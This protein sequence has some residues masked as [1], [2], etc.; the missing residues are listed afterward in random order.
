MSENKEKGM[1]KTLGLVW[2]FLREYKMQMIGATVALTTAAGTVLFMGHGLRNL[3][4][5]GL[6]Q[7]DANYL[8]QALLV[9]LV[10]I[11]ILSAASYSR[12]FL[13]SW[14]GERLIADL[15]IAVYKQLVI[16]DPT[17]YE[18]NKK[19]EIISRLTADTSIL[20]MIV[21]TSLPIGLRNLIMTSGGLFMLFITSPRLTAILLLVVPLVI[22]PIIVLGRRVRKKSR[23][24]QDKV[25]DL[26]GY[27]DETLHAVQTVQACGQELT[28]VKNFSIYADNSFM[29]ATTYIKDR[30]ILTAIVIF[31][32]FGAVGIV[33]WLG[34]HDVLS[35]RI[36][37][38]ELSAFVF[39]AIIVSGSIGSLS[40]VFGA[41]Q[42]GVGAADRLVEILNTSPSVIT[43]QVP[44]RL[45]K[46]VKGDIS[47][48]FLSFSY[49]ARQEVDAL[50][51]LSFDIKSGEKVAIVGP[52]GAGK[53][54]IFQ[55]L[56]RFYDVQFGKILIDK[57]D[58][59]QIP[60][61]DLRS[62][63]A[64]VPQ[65]PVV[66]SSSA[67][68]N[69]RYAS[70]DATDNAVKKAAK[71]AYAHTFIENLPMGYE[72]LLGER[73][74]T[75]SGGQKQ[76]IAIARAFLRNPDILLLDEAT[77][78]LDSESESNVHKALEKL[79]KGRTTL[80]IA[81]RLA[82]VQ[83]ADRILVLDQGH[84][85]DSGTHK[86]LYSKEGLYKHLADLQLKSD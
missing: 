58:I 24:A 67:L 30:A 7:R 21:S 74:C 82:T 61:E 44:E 41:L 84:L 63:I 3:I 45:A 79:M 5:F 42:R 32:I 39:Y 15:R 73:G 9:L 1:A 46:K 71:M 80:I 77:S 28:S 25:G 83:N 20:Q 59:S 11:L 10:V 14:L 47:F 51:N 37:A 70:P 18:A 68:D 33:L 43:P 65:D 12:Y 27:A 62:H 23:I 76:R 19:G 31:L 40:E 55:I 69:I 50:K 17:F 16:L 6:S 29:A 35:G 56:M 81:H 22:I 48:Q 4:D 36:T 64:L 57:I 54:T 8:N 60:P 85:V 78:S 38:G 53:T 13:V 2:Q 66:F 34:G 26:S 86:E 72:T 52:S 49:P 75:L